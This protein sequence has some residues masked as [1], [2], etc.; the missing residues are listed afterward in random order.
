MFQGTAAEVLADVRRYAA[1]GVSHFVFD[2]VRPDARALL[3]TMA[4]FAEDVRPRAGRAARPAPPPAG[5]V[6]G[7]RVPAPRR[8]RRA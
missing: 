1:L 7:S 4:R 2:P 6:K 5:A 3:D 8:D